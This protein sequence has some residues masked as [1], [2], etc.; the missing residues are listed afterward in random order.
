MTPQNP[1][2]T[3]STSRA[4][5]WGISLPKNAKIGE[6]IDLHKLNSGMDLGARPGVQ[7]A[8]RFNGET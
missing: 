1:R 2:Q 6:K 3:D 7:G 5:E 4:G 8:L